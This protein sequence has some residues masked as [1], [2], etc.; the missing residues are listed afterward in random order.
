[1]RHGLGLLVAACSASDLPA[2][3]PDPSVPGCTR[4]IGYA[5]VGHRT[6]GW[7]IAGGVFESLVDDARWE[8]SWNPGGGIDRW[9][10]PAYVGWSRPIE[11]S[12]AGGE[13]DRVLLSVGGPYGDDED[14]WVAGIEAAVGTVLQRLPS[15]RE[16][17]LQTVVGGPDHATCRFEGVDVRASWQHPYIDAAIESVAATS[18]LPVT[19]G[20]SP[21]VEQCGDYTDDHGHLSEEAARVVASQLGAFY[22]GPEGTVWSRR[23]APS[24]SR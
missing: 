21:E 17:V 2:S 18:G 5:Q 4:V 10:N 13:P 14:A 12:C 1:M 19:V 23:R 6:K 7:Y 8:L 3:A 20:P 9:Q 22:A 24:P 11:S 16:V 15:A